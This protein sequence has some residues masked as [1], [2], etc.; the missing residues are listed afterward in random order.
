[1]QLQFR[2]VLALWFATHSL[3]IYLLILSRTV[4]PFWVKAAVGLVAGGVL[5][6]KSL[7]TVQGGHRGGTR[8]KESMRVYLKKMKACILTRNFVH[9]VLLQV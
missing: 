8:R 5:L 1:V 6:E 7:F 4:V 2:P 9:S 3:R